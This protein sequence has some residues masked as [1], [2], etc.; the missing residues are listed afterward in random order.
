MIV[1]YINYFI[2][3]FTGVL[4]ANGVEI[5]GFTNFSANTI[6]KISFWMLAF[7]IIMEIVIFYN[8]EQNKSLKR[9]I[10]FLISL[11]CKF[12]FLLAFGYLIVYFLDK[13]IDDTYYIAS[14]LGMIF[15]GSSSWYLHKK[16]GFY[17][18]RYEDIS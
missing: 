11:F 9:S 16:V 18:D 4:I 13:N 6:Y 2:M 10:L 8:K 7:L 14:I 17:P 5:R 12:I 15:C 3:I 1:A